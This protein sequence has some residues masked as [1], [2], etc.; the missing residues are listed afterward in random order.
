MDM[1]YQDEAGR[2]AKM[3]TLWFSQFLL[4]M[5]LGKLVGY[6]DA[7]PGDQAVEAYFVEARRRL[8]PMDELGSYGVVSVEI[9]CLASIYLHWNDRK[10]D[11]YLYVSRLESSYLSHLA[12][13]L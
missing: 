7:I 11:A 3:Q 10:H 1:L 5:A 12:N 13:I 4:V 9:M 8:P 6:N 2:E